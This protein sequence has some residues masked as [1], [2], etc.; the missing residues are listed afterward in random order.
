M[1]QRGFSL[2]EVLLVVAILAILGG[3]G[4]AYYGNFSRGVEITTASKRLIADIRA[5]RSR[6]IAGEDG[7]RWG[8]HLVN[9]AQD[10]YEV[11]STPTTYT[12]G[13]V[14][15]EAPV[16]LPAGVSFSDPISSATKDILFS[17]IAGTTTATTTALTSSIQNITVTVTESGS[18]Y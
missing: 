1:Q 16:Y 6:A 13:A 14:T 8:V 11:Y 18:T 17:G 12:D 4:A 2:I 10:Y 5:A 7:R 3:A 15:T 9:G